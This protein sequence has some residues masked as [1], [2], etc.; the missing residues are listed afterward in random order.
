[1]LR[2]IKRDG[3]FLDKFAISLVSYKSASV[4]IPTA[5]ISVILVDALLF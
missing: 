3:K 1:M 5:G 4:T 2:I